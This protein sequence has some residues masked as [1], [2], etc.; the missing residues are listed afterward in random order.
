VGTTASSVRHTDLAP[1]DIRRLS[2]PLVPILPDAAY[3]ARTYDRAVP[4]RTLWESADGLQIRFDPVCSR[5]SDVDAD[6]R[7]AYDRLTAELGRVS[8]EA[9]LSPGDI[10]VVDND[11]VVHGRTPFRVRYDGT[12]RWLKRAL[13]HL[14]DRATR[15]ADERHEHGYGQPV[16]DPYCP[17]NARSWG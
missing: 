10:L 7:L 12:D 11:V 15:P 9:V 1:E 13:V 6:S 16:I 2:A 3:T 8:T 5:F 14:P 4:V 17:N